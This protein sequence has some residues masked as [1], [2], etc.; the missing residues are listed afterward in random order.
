M[1]DGRNGKGV[2]VLY[3]D[4]FDE[5]I[6]PKSM[7]RRNICFAVNR[8]FDTMVDDNMISSATL[9]GIALKRLYDAGIYTPK[10]TK[11]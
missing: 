1:V 4:L 9:H 5:R 11:L 8:C 2:Y 10:M 6:V 7:K 3:G